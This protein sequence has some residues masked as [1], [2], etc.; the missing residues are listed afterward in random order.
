MPWDV[1]DLRGAGRARAARPR[2]TPAR[3]AIRR[4]SSEP[5]TCSATAREPDDHGRRR[6][7]GR[8]RRR[9]SSWRSCSRRRS[10]PSAAGAAS[11]ATTTTSGSPAQRA[12]S[13]GT[14]PTCLLGI[15]S[16]L[17]LQWFR[18]PDQPSGLK[19]VNIDI[20]PTKPSASGRRRRS[21][22]T[23][24]AA[25]GAHG[26]RPRRGGSGRSRE[27]EFEAVK[28]ANREEIQ[29]IQPHVQYLAAIRD[30]LPRDGFFVEEICQA[31]FASYYALPGLR[32]AHVRHLRLPG[33]AR[34]S[35]SRRRSASRP[36]TRRSRSSRSRETAASC[37]ACRSWRPRRS[38]AST[39]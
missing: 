7:G 29:Q 28:A 30:V 24:G 22:A 20:D 37:S 1:F 2:P 21:S 19:I 10:S 11:S 31:G 36:A 5:P 3:P 25:A 32:A 23:R 38:T 16:R 17:E 18:W 39:S 33:N 34:A 6:R 35:A 27:A 4:R 14:R 26:R 12:S 8:L 13:A 15:G 9:C